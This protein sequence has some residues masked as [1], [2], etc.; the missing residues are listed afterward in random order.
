MQQLLRHTVKPPKPKLHYLLGFVISFFYELILHFS[1][2]VCSK[3]ATYWGF[4]KQRSTHSFE[5]MGFV[6]AF[7]CS[8]S[9]DDVILRFPLAFRPT[10]PLRHRATSS[11][12][13]HV[14]IWNSPR[15]VGHW[16][17][18]TSF[19]VDRSKK[20]ASNMRILPRLILNLLYSWN[21]MCLKFS[22]RRNSIKFSRAGSRVKWWKNSNVSETISIPSPGR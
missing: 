22:R 7:L 11:F 10:Q 19:R 20:K 8:E 5:E 17:K 6:G 21:N 13:E 3:N 1:P 14:K 16:T 18:T 4:T 12:A 15:Y 9:S 2:T